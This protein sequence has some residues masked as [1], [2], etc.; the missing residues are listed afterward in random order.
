MLVLPP[1]TARY[2][3]AANVYGG[4]ALPMNGPIPMIETNN[5][6]NHPTGPEYQLVV[7]EGTYV[8]RDDIHLAT[9][10]PHPSEAPVVNPNPL[11]TTL[12]PPTAGVKLCLVRL[13]PR[14]TR[15]L[16]HT[17]R[18]GSIAHSTAARNQSI[19]ED[20]REDRTSGDSVGEKAGS[21]EY[22]NE[23]TNGV[24]DETTPAFGEGNSAL[25]IPPTKDT[26]DALKRK[27]PKNNIIKS[28]SSFVSRVIPHE[29]L[30]KR[31]QE[32]KPEDL[33]AFANINR[34]YQWLD[35]SSV[36]KAEQLA[37]ILF[38]KAHALC[39]DVNP[40]TKSASHVD[41]VM[42]FSSGDIIW[43]EPMSQKYARL[44][45]NG[46]INAFPIFEI[47]WIPGSENLF[48]AAHGDGSLVVYDKDKE[49]AAFVAEENGPT[50]SEGADLPDSAASFHVN[51]S[52]NSRNQKFNPIACWKLS[53]QKIT[54]FS[55]SPDCRHL[56]VVSED[57]TLRIIDYLKEQLLDLYNGYYGGLICVCWS[58][59]GKY[60]LTGGQDDLVSI[61][62]LAEC[63][64]V[65]RCQGHCSWVNAVAFD[66]WRCDDRNYRFG[67]VGQDCRLLLWDFSVGMLTR[68][69]AT[70][71]RPRGSISSPN[72]ALNRRESQ[73]TNRFRSDSSLTN[74][75]SKEELN[76]PLTSWSSTATLP[77]IMSKKIDPEPLEWLG[78]EEDCIITACREGHI[79]IWDRPK[80][81]AA[82]NQ[83]TASGTGSAA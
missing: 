56:A 27:K 70:S 16:I 24:D 28:N 76:H 5:S 59:D 15:P 6:I 79:R 14:E 78:F 46:A 82:G 40:I 7:G 41:L 50:Q 39:H 25:A 74:K 18:T 1:P 37:K 77:P 54:A 60:F 17:V 22:A 64:I 44:N 32:R 31:L 67:S 13:A 55:F 11:A 26:K 36:N 81:G 21:D 53:N 48:L 3:G 63:Q 52:V 72:G 66:P 38:T 10:P 51:K 42:G 34:A 47:R 43:Y 9:P 62:S 83:E 73:I 65:A 75:S 23:K 57:G 49:D 69:K 71:V 2:S 68:P 8:L 33:F 35:L 58:P 45:K 19:A 4:A 80:E 29:A 20:A 61:W 12:Q 30:A